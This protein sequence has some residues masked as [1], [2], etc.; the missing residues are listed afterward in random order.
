MKNAILFLTL[1]LISC[2]QKLDTMISNDRVNIKVIK[3]NDLYS[4][5][6]YNR[7]DSLTYDQVTENFI[8]LIENQKDTLVLDNLLNSFK[9]FAGKDYNVLRH[10]KI[11]DKFNGSWILT[12]ENLIDTI[13]LSPA[14]FTFKYP[15]L[16]AVNYNDNL[17]YFAVNKDNISGTYLNNMVKLVKNE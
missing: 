9:N 13:N 5:E 11:V 17:I 8:Q 16:L 10:E 6:I 2:N 14:N 3:T 1:I 7:V 4:M 12:G 15:N